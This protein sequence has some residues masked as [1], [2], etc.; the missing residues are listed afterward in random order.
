M[1]QEIK[2]IGY[3][4]GF[5]SIFAIDGNHSSRIAITRNLELPTRTTRGRTHL[6][7]FTVQHSFLFGIAPDGVFQRSTLL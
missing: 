4:L 3:R 1:N 2:Q 6:L 5:V 7:H